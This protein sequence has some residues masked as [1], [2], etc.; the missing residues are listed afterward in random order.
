MLEWFT[1]PCLIAL[2]DVVHCSLD[3]K[4]HSIGLFVLQPTRVPLLVGK[5]VA[6][7]SS[8]SLRHV[9]Q[10]N[11]VDA[12][13]LSSSLAVYVMVG[14]MAVP[15]QSPIMPV[16][17]RMKCPKTAADLPDFTSNMISAES[18]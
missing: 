7:P 17:V 6:K 3:L 10:D 12:C 13:R 16:N 15:T 1:L 8:H 9:E 2:D 14:A 4:I 5:C 11:L 18:L